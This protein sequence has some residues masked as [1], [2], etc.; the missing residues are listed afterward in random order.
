MSC[1]LF[2]KDNNFDIYFK[3]ATKYYSNGDIQS[4]EFQD[5]QLNGKGNINVIDG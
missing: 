5:G 3:T 4:G 2:T 1:Y